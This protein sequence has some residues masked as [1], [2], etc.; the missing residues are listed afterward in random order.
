MTKGGETCT[1]R[2]HNSQH[3]RS[4]CRWVCPTMGGAQLGP[5]FGLPMLGR[6]ICKSRTNLTESGRHLLRAY[7]KSARNNLSRK[8]TRSP[9]QELPTSARVI[10]PPA[11]GG[12][13]DGGAPQSPWSWSWGRR[14]RATAWATFRWRCPWRTSH[15]PRL[16]LIKATLRQAQRSRWVC[17]AHARVRRTAAHG[18]SGSS[19]RQP[20][21]PARS[22]NQ[23]GAHRKGSS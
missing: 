1:P 7:G 16:N 23:A 15:R 2:H 22:C 10:D 5:D 9:T 8:T 3:V 6:L 14:W 13:A 11:R 19:G 12:A 20:A 17:D 21:A 4:G 18:T